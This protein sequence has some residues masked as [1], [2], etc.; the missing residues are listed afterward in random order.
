MPTAQAVVAVVITCYNEGAYIG[1]AVRSVL[2]QTR[3]D[4]I[5]SIV[6][7]DDGSAADTIAVLEQIERWDARIRVIYGKGGA[8]LPAQ[9]N[10]AIRTTQTPFI[11]ILDGDDVWTANKLQSQI[12]T[13]VADPTVGLVYAGYF[14]FARDLHNCHRAAVLDITAAADLPRAYFLNDPPIIPSTTIIRR[15]AFEE[16]GGFDASVRVFE[17]TDFYL[18]L[19]RTCRFAFTAEPLLYKRSRQASIT[20][21]RKDLMVHHAFVAF[22]AAADNPRLLTLVP[23]RLAERARKLGN[24]YF[25]LGQAQKARPLLR[26]AVRLNPINVRA[27]VSWLASGPYASAVHSIMAA[28]WK[29]RLV[30][31][32]APPDVSH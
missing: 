5:D 22:R 27:W 10:L 23:Q 30:A 21:S 6:I 16:C 29:R 12:P 15:T 20:G 1:A 24:H 28:R 31:M 18:R 26:L 4:L 9:R 3:A 19:A 25:L 8:G 17:D 32:G 14:T 2:G 13:M 7:V 11:A